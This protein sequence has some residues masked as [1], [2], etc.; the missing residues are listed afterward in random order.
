MTQD[1]SVQDILGSL[2]EM[3]NKRG[4]NNGKNSA[5]TKSPSFTDDDEDDDVIELVNVDNSKQHRK[6]LL[7]EV[8][9]S[10]ALSQIKMFAENVGNPSFKKHN[11]SADKTVEDFIVELIKPYLAEWLDANLP[12]IVEKI[13]EKEIKQLIP[14]EHD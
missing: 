11:P 5:D 12:K 7:S 9:T 14:Q 13:V 8:T 10:D 6:S 3:I 1:V 4:D 2:K